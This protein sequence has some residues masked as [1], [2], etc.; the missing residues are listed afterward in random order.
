M[1]APQ[2]TFFQHHLTMPETC[3]EMIENVFS[4]YWLFVI[5]NMA[6]LA[7]VADIFLFASFQI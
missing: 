3:G 2:R 4:C 6:N 7:V 5:V 1:I